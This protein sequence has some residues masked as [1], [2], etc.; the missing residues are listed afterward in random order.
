MNEGLD[1]EATRMTSVR[2]C[3]P[4]RRVKMRCCPVVG[5]AKCERCLRKSME[6]VSYVQRKRG[7][8]PLKLTG[9]DSPHGPSR[10]ITREASTIPSK[11]EYMGTSGLP[12]ATSTDQRHPG[13]DHRDSVSSNVWAKIDGLQPSSLL[14]R[15]ATKEKYSLQSILSIS[16]DLD[17]D[18]AE[19]TSCLPEDDPVV[20]GIVSY[21]IATSLFEGQSFNPFICVLDPSLHTFQYIRER[22]SFLLTVMLS[23][24]AKAFNPTLHFDLH[25]YSERLFN[26][27]IARGT[28]SP[29]VIQA[30]LLKTYWK[31]SDD[32]RSWPILGYAIRLSMELGWHKLSSKDEDTTTMSSLEIRRRRNVE[33]TWLVLFVYDRSMSLQNGN[34]WMIERSDFIESVNTWYTSPLATINDTILAAFV[35]LRLAAANILEV[36]NPRRPAPSVTHAYRFNSLLKTLT[37][38]VE[39]WK[40]RWG[41][42]ASEK[43]RC[44]PFLVSFFG[45]HLLLLLYSFPLQSSIS[46]Q[47]GASVVDTEAFWIT[48]TSAMDMLKQI[49]HPS[50]TPL[51][52]F[53]HDSIHAMTAYAAVFLIK[54]L[55]S[56]K[57]LTRK[58]Y[59][60][61]TIEAI[62][63][64]ARVFEQQSTPPTFTCSLQASFL[65]NVVQEY[66]R[67]CRQHLSRHADE[68]EHDPSLYEQNTSFSV[69][70]GNSGI[71]ED[72]S[73]QRRILSP[74]TLE[75]S[76]VQ[77]SGQY[78]QEGDALSGYQNLVASAPI[79]G[80]AKDHAP[81]DVGNIAFV[82]DSTVA[83]DLSPQDWE[84]TNEDWVSLSMNAGF[85]ITDGIFIPI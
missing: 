52:S 81:R 10:R 51:L 25:R 3:L 35:S 23:V 55:L 69:M 57:S 83:Q 76:G 48:Y 12:A 59:E 49:S 44:H 60:K 79:V 40:K 21:H 18:Q 38:Q 74:L 53:A 22:S 16:R 5:S 70:Q 27:A 80:T 47:S 84:F 54:L 28:K 61:A 72:D 14:T 50:L 37:P 2:A 34:P 85:D 11:V 24:S 6:C 77:E 26:D 78:P 62:D 1:S 9:A 71:N 41:H 63:M 73:A 66:K 39:A 58:E 29:E 64:A 7:R 30:I 20:K 75:P 15:E 17:M 43:E 32:T 67:T 8:K 46:S 42:I 13:H 68:Q 33:R 82:A 65:R 56:V 4:C 36:F 19:S 31:Q 45:T